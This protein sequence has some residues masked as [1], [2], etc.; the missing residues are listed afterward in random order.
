MIQ[1]S[2]KT[3][4]EEATKIED[5]Y[6]EY[7]SICISIDK[8]TRKVWIPHIQLT[9]VPKA[10]FTTIKARKTGKQ[11]EFYNNLLQVTIGTNGMI[12]DLDSLI[13]HPKEVD[14]IEGIDQLMR[15]DTYVNTGFI[16]SISHN[17]TRDEITFRKR[18]Q[19][20]T[21]EYQNLLFEKVQNRYEDKDGKIEK[22]E[23]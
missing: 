13:P 5:F 6:K 1:S 21:N 16:M 2:K 8:M 12:Y 20:F 18:V 23:F 22:T 4:E 10:Y 3:K 19:I 9:E 11:R 14:S 17:E 15:P 7:K